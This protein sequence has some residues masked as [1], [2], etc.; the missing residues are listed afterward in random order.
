M[1]CRS[2]ATAKMSGVMS[3]PTCLSDGELK[4]PW[5]FYVFEFVSGL[6]LAK[7]IP[8]FVLGISGHWFQ[9]PFG[10]PPGVDESSPLS[11]TLWGYAHLAVG[12]VLLWFFG[13]QGSAVGWILVALGVLFAAVWES[14]NFGRVRS[15][16]GG[17]FHVR[18]SLSP[19]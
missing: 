4:M 11:N 3:A 10:Y 8:H 5:Y 7:G 18:R 19:W 16:H 15:S 2:S 9:S 13:P 6:F 1:K 12:F 14:T 17:R